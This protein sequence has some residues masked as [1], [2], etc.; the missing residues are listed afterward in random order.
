VKPISLFDRLAMPMHEA[1][2]PSLSSKPNVAP[3]TA[4]KARIP[5]DVNQPGAVG[6]DLSALMDF[7]SYDRVD[8]QLLNAILFADARHTQLVWPT[9]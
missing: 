4:V 5:F 7:S 2:L 8:E 1:F 6:A 9:R 3:Y